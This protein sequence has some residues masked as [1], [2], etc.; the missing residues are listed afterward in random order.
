MILSAL[1]IA[2]IASRMRRRCAH[3]GASATL[4][5]L[6]QAL[7]LQITNS[8]LATALSATPCMPACARP[9]RLAA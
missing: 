7:A 6:D 5:S 8:D 3:A 9:S 4:R 1:L 2:G